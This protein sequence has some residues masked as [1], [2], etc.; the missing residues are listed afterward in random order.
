MSIWSN[1]AP[2]GF[3]MQNKIGPGIEV[4]PIDIRP[5]LDEYGLSDGRSSGTRGSRKKDADDKPPKL[6]GMYGT[7]VSWQRLNAKLDQLEAGQISEKY[8]KLFNKASESERPQLELA[9]QEEMRKAADM[10]LQL[11]PLEN[12]SKSNRALWDAD[13][14]QVGTKMIHNNLVISDAFANSRSGNEIYNNIRTIPL[15]SA[16]DGLMVIPTFSEYYKNEMDNSGI[17]TDERSGNMIATTFTS[18]NLNQGN[19][20]DTYQDI[21]KKLA[22]AKTFDEINYNGQQLTP[23]NLASIMHGDPSLK[24]KLTTNRDNIMSITRN[25]LE[26]LDPSSKANIYSNVLNGHISVPTGKVE[27]ATGLDGLPAVYEEDIKEGDKVI[28][29]KGDPIMTVQRS[30]VPGIIAVNEILRAQNELTRERKP[31]EAELTAADKAAL[32]AK[33]KRY[34]DA[35]YDAAQIYAYSMATGQEI[36]LTSMQHDMTIDTGLK[37]KNESRGDDIVKSPYATAFDVGIQNKEQSVYVDTP[38]GKATPRSVP[39]LE[40]NAPDAIIAE[41]NRMYKD[42]I[43][44]FNLKDKNIKNFMIGSYSM[45]ISALLGGKIGSEFQVGKIQGETGRLLTTIKFNTSEPDKNGFFSKGVYQKVT[46]KDKNGEDVIEWVP[47]EQKYKEIIVD[48]SE[49]TVMSFKYNGKVYTDKLIRLF[50]DGGPY[51]DIGLRADLEKQGVKFERLDSNWDTH[52]GY[53]VNIFIPVDNMELYGETT[54]NNRGSAA[55]YQVSQSTRAQEGRTAV[56]KRENI[57]TAQDVAD[58]A[59]IIKNNRAA[60]IRE[61]REGVRV[62]ETPIIDD[63]GTMTRNSMGGL[64]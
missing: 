33:G 21:R 58:A 54:A 37:D 50:G 36:G 52:D 49:E 22:E 10:R 62:Q 5:F 25:A 15:F 55:N 46:T 20:D 6:D 14:K 35:I 28:H 13:M 64:R 23:E 53:R 56:N 12:A 26:I 8:M 1:S 57:I 24:E 4:K 27:Q 47:E 30:G 16:K 44:N 61:Q 2:V 42:P 45:P 19:T 63:G 41:R 48:V 31:G 43:L 17:T 59:E 40:S 34:A 38:I 11:I 39:Y 29:K 7:D 32:I 3:A 51:R 18:A 60:R 9:Y